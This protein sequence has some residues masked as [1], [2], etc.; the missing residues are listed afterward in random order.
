[1]FFCLLT[2][3]PFRLLLP[4]PSVCIRIPRPRHSPEPV[5]TAQTKSKRIDT[6]VHGGVGLPSTAFPTRKRD[7]LNFS[8]PT[9]LIILIAL[10]ILL[11]LCAIAY[12]RMRKGNTFQLR[13]RF[14][15]EYDRA[16]VEH[17]SERKAETKLADRES[18]VDKLKL[19]DLGDAQR[20]RFM[21]DWRGVESRFIDHPKGAVTEADELVSSL[22]LARGYPASS[23]EQSAED[24]SVNH[25]GMMENYRSAHTIAMRSGNA[26][27]TT[28]DLRAAMIDYR[29]LFDELV[30]VQTA[31]GTRSA[32]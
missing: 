17:G 10:V 1:L 18:R 25:S 31:A 28:E 15:T 12:A 16:V 30:Q 26:G 7:P 24:I 21:T 11:A 27:T 4:L 14:G 23:F 32:S 22:L 2:P 3:L 6:L 20:D 5:H 13:S 8:S 19:R 29:N 9:F